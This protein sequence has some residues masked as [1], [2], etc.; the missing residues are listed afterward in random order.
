MMS[1]P[2]AGD[3]DIVNL[4]LSRDVSCRSRAYGSFFAPGSDTGCYYGEY[5]LSFA[6]STG[7]T[8]IVGCLLDSDPGAVYLVDSFGNTAFHLAILHARIDAYR[9]LIARSGQSAR[10]VAELHGALGMTPL[11]FAALLRCVADSTEKEEASEDA[12]DQLLDSIKTVAWEFTEVVSHEFPLAQ[13]DSIPSA[14]QPPP[15]CAPQTAGNTPDEETPADPSACC[16]TPGDPRPVAP[17]WSECGNSGKGVVCKGGFSRVSSDL[18]L[19][20]VSILYLVVQHDLQHLA[21]ND[22]LCRLLEEKWA[23]VRLYYYFGMLTQFSYLGFITAL[24]VRAHPSGEADMAWLRQTVTVITAL[25][26]SASAVD[27]ILGVIYFARLRKLRH[28]VQKAG[29]PPQLTG[30]KNAWLPYASKDTLIIG[31]THGSTLMLF[32]RSY[33]LRIFDIIAWVGYCLYVAYLNLDGIVNRPL[34]DSDD[35]PL[36]LVFLGFSALCAWMSVLTFAPVHERTGML[37]TMMTRTIARDLLP[38]LCV[39]CFIFT[40]ISV[41]LF[42]LQRE[43][44]SLL[45]VM[46]MLELRS[47]G[48][49]EGG[50]GD[51]GGHGPGLREVCFVMV[52]VFTVIAMV[53]MLNLLIA[54][55]TSTYEE[56][57]DSAHKEWRL[58]W[59]RD[60]LLLERRL[61]LWP[62]IYNRLRVNHRED[63]EHAFVSVKNKSRAEY[64]PGRHASAHGN[65]GR[66][67]TQSGNDY[68]KY[69][70]G[71]VMRGAEA[72][73]APPRKKK[74]KKPKRVRGAPDSYSSSHAGGAAGEAGGGATPAGAGLTAAVEAA[75][76]TRCDNCG[77]LLSYTTSSYPVNVCVC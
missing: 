72:A 53:L 21:E 48:L 54:T 8:D 18:P 56:V 19:R 2:P 40:G 13:L 74:K 16:E 70:A 39:F 35:V 57:K 58:Q 61:S 62:S 45:Q 1:K 71:S 41:T 7:R 55:F 42:A 52:L 51:P 9:D 4:L 5:A 10:D 17:A 22:L 69:L 34:H 36:K 50:N 59:G 27:V 20:F 25:N 11:G 3:V 65:N 38:F 49:G 12:F 30:K 66:L 73:A 60:V 63:G 46:D 47:M 32:I 68:S 67:F 28:G 37:V 43:G 64:R 44:H 77:S 29:V 26:A 75:M 23:F 15:Q 14:A 31:F 24:T 76:K 33:P 6:A